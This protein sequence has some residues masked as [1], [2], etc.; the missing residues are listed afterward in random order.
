MVQEDRVGMGYDAQ[1]GMAWDGM[2]RTWILPRY[3]HGFS[4]LVFLFPLSIFLPF[5]SSSK[6]FH[7]PFLSCIDNTTF[8]MP[9]LL[10]CG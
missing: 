10:A 1:D 7:V 6:H 5:R 8:V 3:L 2:D 9:L 4:T